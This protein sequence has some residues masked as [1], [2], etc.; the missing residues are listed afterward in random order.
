[1]QTGKLHRHNLIL[2]YGRR[3]WNKVINFK[4]MMANWGAPWTAKS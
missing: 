4:E 1:M 2:I 3:Y